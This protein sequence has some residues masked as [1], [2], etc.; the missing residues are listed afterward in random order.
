MRGQSVNK[1]KSCHANSMS[2]GKLREVVALK[3]NPEENIEVSKYKWVTIS[4][5][6]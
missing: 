4:G 6:G 2:Q 1:E 3:W 5:V